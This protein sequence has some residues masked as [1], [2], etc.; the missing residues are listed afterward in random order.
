MTKPLTRRDPLLD[1]LVDRAHGFA[2]IYERWIA[3]RLG[4][5]VTLARL[6]VLFILHDNGPQQMSALARAAKVAARTLTTFV[7]ALEREGLARRVPHD[8]DRRATMVEIT[9]AGIRAVESKS[10]PYWAA[11]NF[12]YGELKLD[13]AQLMIRIYDRWFVMVAEDLQRMGVDP[14]AQA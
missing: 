3:K 9:P 5:G 4:D 14:E 13:E 12:L 1:V 2:Q 7:D 11:K 10:A 8:T 6:R